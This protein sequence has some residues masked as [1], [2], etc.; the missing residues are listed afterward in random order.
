MHGI[1]HKSDLSLDAVI[2]FFSFGFLLATP[3]AIVVESII[4]NM[5]IATYYLGYLI[6]TIFSGGSLQSMGDDEHW[7]YFSFQLAMAMVES[8][9]VAALSEEFCK[10]YTFRTIEHPDLI[11]L[12]GLDRSK[13]DETA[14]L[15]GNSAYPFSLENAS[16]LVNRCGSFETDFIQASRASKSYRGY[17]PIIR[18][19]NNRIPPESEET[20]EE[21]EVRTIN[22]QAAA[23]TTG[24]F[25]LFNCRRGKLSYLNS[26]SCVLL[27]SSNC[28]LLLYYTALISTAVGLACAENFL[29]VFILSHGSST[30][31]DIIL[32]FFRSLFP[33]H[34]LCAALQS[35][36]IVRK[37][38]EN[39]DT[40]SKRIGV[41]RIVLPAIF[42][43]GTFD[44]VIMTVNIC[45][46]TY[47]GYQK[48]INVIG[49]SSLIVIM[50]GGTIWYYVQ[51]RQQC[52]R[53]K[54]MGVEHHAV[55]VSK[56]YIHPLPPVL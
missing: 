44:F 13:K 6:S 17:N 46:D 16:A 36:S 37:F 55:N 29:Y 21:P 5:V 15:G 34:A 9:L 30:K 12:T 18:D 54:T 22:Q 49:G 32:L 25:S 19:Q 48:W 42:L 41:G 53:L 2:K 43:H 52:L 11:F 51:N 45:I 14:L 38:L 24:A 39:D 23:V 31:E 35:T 50:V 7:Y 8:Y 40:V 10:Y 3:A 4:L 47:S 20:D 28:C 33:V 26:I 27:Y 56:G 1:F